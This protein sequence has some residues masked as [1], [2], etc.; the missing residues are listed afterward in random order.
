[1]YG[2]YPLEFHEE[3]I[4]WNKRVLKENVG[5]KDHIYHFF[6]NLVHLYDDVKEYDLVL[7]YGKRALVWLEQRELC[8]KK[9]IWQDMTMVDCMAAAAR[10]LKKFEESIIYERQRLTLSSKL[11]QAGIS[12][13]GKT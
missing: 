4:Y 9:K 3:S 8:K 10:H 12:H 7:E 11:E 5:D 13:D 1:M 2:L 6:N